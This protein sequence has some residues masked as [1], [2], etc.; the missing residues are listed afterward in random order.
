MRGRLLYP[1]FVTVLFLLLSMGTGYLKQPASGEQEGNDFV[2]ICRD[3]GAGGYEAF[4]DVC[5]LKDG[6]LMAV[7]YAGCRFEHP[8]GGPTRIEVRWVHLLGRWAYP[9]RVRF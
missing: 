6:G 9:R 7:F 8:A 3:A 4:P 2:Y 1:L 5:R